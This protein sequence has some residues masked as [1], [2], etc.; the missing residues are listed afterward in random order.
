MRLFT[1]FSL[2]LFSG[3]GQLFSQTT[4]IDSLK[5]TLNTDSVYSS[6]DIQAEHPEGKEAR[7]RFIEKNVDA[8]I[9]VKNGAPV[10]TYKIRIACIVDANGKIITM[11]P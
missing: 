8:G 9:G 5:S 11:V 7:I 2:F 10:G 6:V 1:V 3:F 4:I